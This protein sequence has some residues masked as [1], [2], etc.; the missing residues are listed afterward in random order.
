LFIPANITIIPLP[1]K[2]SEL[3][4]VEIENIWQYMRDNW[5][6]NRIFKI[7][8]RDYCRYASE[9]PRRPS[10]ENHVHQAAPMGARVLINEMW[11]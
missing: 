5:L 9:Y 4:P 2:C 1:P 6:S 3:N 8:R 7:L 10:L 11:Y